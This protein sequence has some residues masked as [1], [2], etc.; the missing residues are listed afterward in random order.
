M[1]AVWPG[2][3]TDREGARAFSCYMPV[4]RL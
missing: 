3:G 4:D 2:V 1:S